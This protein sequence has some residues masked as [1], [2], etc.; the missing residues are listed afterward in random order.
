MPPK[1]VPTEGAYQGTRSRSRN[2]PQEQGY[3]SEEEEE[4]DNTRFESPELDNRLQ[5][6]PPR[7]R[8]RGN[9]A[10]LQL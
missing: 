7:Q 3:K 8:P 10:G 4:G 6:P 5:S 2:L 1:Q 9:G